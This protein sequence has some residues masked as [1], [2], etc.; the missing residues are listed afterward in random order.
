MI[1]QALAEEAAKDP[2]LARY[3]ELHGRLLRLRD[4]ARS[5]IRAA[6]ENPKNDVLEARLDEGKPLID[7]SL[8][9]IQA[10]R[11]AELATS[12][13]HVL[14]EFGVGVADAPLPDDTSE[15]L[16]LARERF[17]RG[18]ALTAQ[19]T[20]VL[21]GTLPEAAAD[22]ALGPYLGWAAERLLPL[23]DL[24]TWKR[25]ACPACGGAPDFAVL[26]EETGSRQLMCSRCASLWP[27][28]RLGCP[29]CG[30]TEHTKIAYHISED[31][32]YRLYFCRECLRYL[33]TLDQ[34]QA[35]SDV[36]LPLERIR[37]LPMDLAAREE[38]YT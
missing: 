25:G 23:V 17:E 38:G 34:R 21:E 12:I 5:G 4:E 36:S 20:P 13:A 19:C 11:F 14:R 8:L 18:Q 37:T 22:L 31:G 10:E 30:T 24:A 27:F 16:A 32:A 29:F 28:R 9:P 3:Y 1:Q 2:E 33:K 6:L 35:A 7:F 15:W 26:D